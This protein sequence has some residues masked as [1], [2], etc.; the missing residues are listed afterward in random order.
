MDIESVYIEDFADAMIKSAESIVSDSPHLNEDVSPG[1]L[2]ERAQEEAIKAMKESTDA[3]EQS[4]K[5]HVKVNRTED[6][7]SQLVKKILHWRKQS[8][9]I[10]ICLECVSL[11]FHYLSF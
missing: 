3:E 5:A 7:T 1:E 10:G 4:F 11:L 9:Q 8:T 6:S 2:L